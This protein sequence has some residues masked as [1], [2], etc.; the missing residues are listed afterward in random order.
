MVN[1]ITAALLI[2]FAAFSRIIPHPANFTSV[3]A[4]ALFSGVY[5]DKKYAF[6]I[7]VA[8]M[9]I[10]DLIIGFHSQMI[11]VYGSFLVIVFL[12]FWLKSRNTGTAGKRVGYILGT[13]ILSSILFFA[14]TNFGVW[15]SGYY[16]L[17]LKGL[18]ES[19]VL[20]IPFFRNTIAG[21]L[22]YVTAMFGVYEVIKHYTRSAVLS[23]S[24]I[25]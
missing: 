15:A 23:E 6:I 21:D 9:L 5:L 20:A 4:I 1:F 13:T 24:K 19:Y 12:G 18:A 3:A 17:D 7:P 16:G 14:I 8:A 25:K 22:I 10:S 11:W 2:L